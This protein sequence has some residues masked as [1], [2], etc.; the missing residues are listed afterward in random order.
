M[1]LPTLQGLIKRRLLVTYG[2]SQDSP[3]V[4]LQPKRHFGYTITS[5]GLIR[6]EQ[7]P[8]ASL[9]EILSPAIA[10]WGNESHGAYLPQRDTSPWI[11]QLAGGHLFPN[12][13]HLFAHAM[14]QED[15]ELTFSFKPQEPTLSIHCTSTMADHL[16]E[17]SPRLQSP[18]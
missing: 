1:R 7:A 18:S 15:G 5:F 6:L 13:P 17:I 9:T 16:P 3:P 10:K 8:P 4:R 2:T 14:V 12:E 11:N